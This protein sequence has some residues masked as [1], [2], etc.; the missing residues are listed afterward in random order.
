MKVKKLFKIFPRVERTRIID[1]NSL[2]E[3]YSG[4][5]GHL[6][7]EFFELSID[8]AR[9]TIDLKTNKPMLNIYIRK[10]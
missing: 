2:K 4:D 3:L 7:V 6:P 10:D 1:T 8:C 9:S 5:M